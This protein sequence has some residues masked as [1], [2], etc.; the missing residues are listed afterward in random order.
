MAKAAVRAGVE[1]LWEQMGRPGIQRVYLA[2]GFGYYLDVEAAFAIG[3]LPGQM[4]GSVQ[5]VGNTS[6]EGAFRIGR[7]LCQEVTDKHM[8]EGSL[9]S[10]KSINLA[11]QEKF[12]RLYMGYMDLCRN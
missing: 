3:L 9:S 12:E 1:I 5:A 10:I 11:K 4:R 7:D 2:G 8:L 6:L